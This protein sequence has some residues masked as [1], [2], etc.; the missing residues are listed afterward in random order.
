V[1]IGVLGPLLVRSDDGR[2]WLP[3]GEKQRLLFSLLL[4]HAPRAV[5]VDRLIEAM[6]DDRL[7]DDPG[8]ALRTQLS[9]LRSGLAQTG[10][11]RDIV[12][13]EPR[14][15]RLDTAFLDIDTVRFEEGL[16]EAREAPD[17]ES[18]LAALNRALGLWRGEPWED[19]AEHPAF[20][21]AARSL[22]ELR[23]GAKER[24][25]ACLLELGRTAEALSEAELLT[26]EDPLRER[27]QA[28][29]MQAL[30]RSGRA[31]EALSAYQEYRRALSEE[32][33]LDPSPAI[34]EL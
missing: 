29:L 8:A 24:R 26:R 19:F 15:Y 3:A 1:H 10:A 4:L 6:W 30:Y 33:G 2:P 18:E 9:R 14:G 31:P 21:G 27:P 16:K 32:L 23:T 34:R 20:V 25:V 17:G 7:P 12:H 28:L 22:V 11:A 5:S 13:S